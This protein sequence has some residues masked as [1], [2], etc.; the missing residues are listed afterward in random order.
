MVPKLRSSLAGVGMVIVLAGCAGQA[1]PGGAG[2][3]ATTSAWDAPTAPSSAGSV[4]P[5]SARPSPNRLDPADRRLAK[6]LYQLSSQ[7]R[8]AQSSTAPVVGARRT[9]SR[10]VSDMRAAV[11]RERDAAYGTSVRS[12]TTVGAQL[13]AARAA[14]ADVRAAHGKLESAL[15]DRTDGLD[16]LE[17]DISKVRKALAARGA[18]AAGASAADVRAATASAKGQARDDLARV[19]QVGAA[20]GKALTSAERLR[21]QAER[22]AAKAC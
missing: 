18:S 13:T 10:A 12:C 19:Q 21:A 16:R 4:S 17:A 5:A 11:K 8:T 3:T 7:L 9:L 14:Q 2:S 1:A 15:A 6:A 20:A 22:I